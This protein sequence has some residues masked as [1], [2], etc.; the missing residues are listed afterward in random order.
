[1]LEMLQWKNACVG[2][3]N[4]WGLGALRGGALLHGQSAAETQRDGGG[5]DG[6]EHSHGSVSDPSGERNPTHSAHSQR[7]GLVLLNSEM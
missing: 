3:D 6:E 1:M 4:D 7:R 5:R 2:W